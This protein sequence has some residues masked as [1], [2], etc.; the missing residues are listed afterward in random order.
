MQENVE[1]IDNKF[2]KVLGEIVKSHRKKLKKSMYAISAESCISKS[3]WREIEL[4][5]CKDVKLKSLYKIAYGLNIS[6][7]TLL[8][9]LEKNLGSNFI[10]SDFD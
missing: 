6:G 3:T 9:E 10:F 8:N 4:G 1:N 2:M 7:S 5:V